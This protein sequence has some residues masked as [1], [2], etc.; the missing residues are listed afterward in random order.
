M[1][2]ASN[3]IKKSRDKLFCSA[4]N[5]LI[6]VVVSMLFVGHEPLPH[7]TGSPAS[8]ELELRPGTSNP[9]PP[10]EQHATFDDCILPILG[11]AQY[12]GGCRVA[13]VLV[14][15]RCVKE[16]ITDALGFQKPQSS[17]AMV[18]CFRTART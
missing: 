16:L 13:H 14:E 9:F 15:N 12:D 1:P 6:F 11:A 17:I 7:V 2:L 4:H 5:N 18:S 3:D 10:L 8:P